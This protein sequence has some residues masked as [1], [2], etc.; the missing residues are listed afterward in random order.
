MRGK[1]WVI[2]LNRYDDRV[3]DLFERDFI[4]RY[5]FQEEE[6]SH[7]HIQGYVEYRERRTFNRV[8]DDWKGAHIEPAEGSP[9]QNYKYCTKEDSRVNGGLNGQRGEFIEPRAEKRKRTELKYDEAIEEIRNGSSVKQI[10]RKYPKL[11]LRHSQGIPSLVGYMK[12]DKAQRELCVILL[13]GDSGTGKS[14]WAL[15]YCMW[16][17]F[18]YYQKPAGEWWGQYSGE[19]VVIMNDMDVGQVDYRKILNWLDVYEC[20]LDIKGGHVK[21]EYHTVILTSNVDPNLW[22][23]SNA[24]E[25]L[26]RRI[27]YTFELTSGRYA[28][29]VVPFKERYKPNE[30]HQFEMPDIQLSLPEEW[31]VEEWEDSEVY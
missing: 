14:F 11:F 5:V 19:E 24:I 8:K 23:P 17:G 20:D 9:W 21:A 10:A 29:E 1:R 31:E 12:K 22:F 26:L 2:T 18:S 4:Q 3:G 13:K 28:S 30:L 15:Q 25:P 16:H 7:R 6:G 27:N